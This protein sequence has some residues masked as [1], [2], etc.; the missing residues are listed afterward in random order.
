MDNLT[1]ETLQI[2]HPPVWDS[3]RY[4]SVLLRKAFERTIPKY[5]NDNIKYTIL[6]YGCGSRPYEYIFK[7]RIE[8]YTGIDVGDNPFADY[9]IQPGEKLSFRDN[10]FD[11]IMSSQV[12]EHVQDVDGYLNECFRVLKPGGILFLSTHGTWQYHAAPYDFYRWTSV[13]IKHLLRKFN[14]EILEFIPILGQLALTSQLRLSFFNSFAEMIGV[15]GKILL[16]PISILYQIKM[17]L[18]DL[19]TPRRVKE[20]DSA[21]YLIVALKKSV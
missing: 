14:F 7:S 6:D 8:K 5:I 13:G 17:K 10:Y 2:I 18:E 1:K 20:R 16:A 15:I 3:Y 21:I 12:L 11:I 4:I 19:V 9:K